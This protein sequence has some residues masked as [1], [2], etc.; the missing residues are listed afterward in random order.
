MDERGGK[1][2][3]SKQTWFSDQ[4]SASELENDKEKYVNFLG[5]G[6]LRKKVRRFLSSNISLPTFLLSPFLFLS[7]H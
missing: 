6:G 2:I 5:R 3:E 4:R 7:S 1:K